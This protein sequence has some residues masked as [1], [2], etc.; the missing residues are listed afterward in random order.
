[1][2][3]QGETLGLMLG[4]KKESRERVAGGFADGAGRG[5]GR[6]HDLPPC[7]SREII[8]GWFAGVPR[9]SPCSQGLTL[10]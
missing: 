3:A 10:G 4:T 1:M 2:L 8:L 5:A 9:A 7:L 6:S